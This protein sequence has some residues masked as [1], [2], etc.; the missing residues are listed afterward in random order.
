MRGRW[1][2][3]ALSLAALTAVA[4]NAGAE[5]VDCRRVNRLPATIARSGVYCLVDN[6]ATAAA[7]GTAIT[8][9]ADDV[10]LDLNGWTL[11]GSAA[12][13]GTETVGIGSVGHSNI[14]VKNG[15][16][17]GFHAGVQLVDIGT[18]VGHVVEGIRAERNTSS[19]LSVSALGAR[20]RGNQVLHTGGSTVPL[21][22]RGHGI[23]VNA[24]A[25]VVADNLVVATTSTAATFA[26]G[27][28]ATRSDG[29]VI[30]GNRVLNEVVA[31]G[32]TYGI[33]IPFSQDVLVVNN[34]VTRTTEGVVYS[35]GATG[36]Y[37]DNL[38]SGVAVP[39]SGTGTDAGNNN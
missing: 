6:L 26:Y 38:T 18:S 4:T 28:H 33:I 17:R 10:V 36:K 21:T 7:T 29:L 9:N 8:I 14:T 34:R 3:G 30:E 13:L 32:T 15:T 11:D 35:S 31:P 20:V 22:S 12:G 2:T 1:M 39:F 16:V 5:T 23:A 19:G 37:R 25:G 27:I 24:P